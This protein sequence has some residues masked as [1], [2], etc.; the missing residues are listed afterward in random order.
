MLIVVTIFLI[1]LISLII[2]FGI[3]ILKKI[4]LQ[5]IDNNEVDLAT[6]EPVREL[7]NKKLDEIKELEKERNKLNEKLQSTL[8]KKIEDQFINNIE[9]NKQQIKDFQKLLDE[10]NRLFLGNTKK[11]GTLSETILE[12]MLNIICNTEIKGAIIKRQDKDINNK[13]PD[14]IIESDNNIYPQITIDSKF[15]VDTWT[16]YLSSTKSDNDKNVLVKAIKVHI[17]DIS[18]KYI[19]DSVPFAIMFTPLED[20]I[21]KLSS[22]DSF[23]FGKDQKLK[24]VGELNFSEFCFNK[25]IVP[26]SPTTIIAVLT[27][28]ER[29]F[30][31]F[32]KLNEVDEKTQNISIWINKHSTLTS[33]FKTLGSDI[34]K[35]IENY[36]KIINNFKDLNKSSGFINSKEIEEIKNKIKNN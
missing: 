5:K 1:I 23:K 35:V 33:N 17:N 27:T 9:E 29:Y 32:Q 19:H 11:V 4:K 21:L 31:L 16:N 28:L 2:F 8:E 7:Y 36:N 26:V 3:F 25:K 18:D 13:I 15:P 24:E 22:D 6:Y 34:T 20:M 30:D 14:L 10:V 12:R